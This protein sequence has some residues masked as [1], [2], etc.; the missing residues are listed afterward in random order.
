MAEQNY[1][2][3]LRNY[4]NSLYETRQSYINLNNRGSGHPLTKNTIDVYSSVIKRFE[5]L[6]PELTEQ[7]KAQKIK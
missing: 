3:R 7:P 6:F 1:L 2:E 4:R 5:K